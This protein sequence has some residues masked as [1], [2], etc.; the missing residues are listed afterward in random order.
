MAEQLNN[1]LLYN[2]SLAKYF[3][4]D[5]SDTLRIDMD[6]TIGGNLTVTGTTTS[7]HSESVLLKDSFLDLNHGYSADT[8]QQGGL[9]V[10]YDPTTTKTTSASF[11]AGAGSDAP[12][13]TVASSSGFAVDDIIQISDATDVAND[14][15]YLIKSIASNDMMVYG[16]GGTSV[17]AAHTWAKNQFTTNGSD[18]A[19]T[20][21]KVAISIMKVDSSGDWQVGK[22]SNIGSL[23]YAAIQTGTDSS[24][25]LQSAYEAGN[26]IT[27]DAST[28]AL[29]FAGNQAFTVSATGGTD[30]SGAAVTV[31][32]G[33]LNVTGGALNVDN[34]VDIDLT[35]AFA[36]DGNQAVSFG[37]ST[38]VASYAVDSAGEIDLTTAGALDLNSAAGS[39]DA[40]TLSI[41]STDTT[42]ITMTANSGSAKT[43]TIKSENSGGGDGK[44][45]IDADDRLDVA[46][47][48]GGLALLSGIAPGAGTANDGMAVLVCT[49]SESSGAGNKSGM[50][51]AASTASATETLVFQAKN[52]GSG[53]SGIAKFEAVGPDGSDNGKVWLTTSANDDSG[54]GESGSVVIDTK[55]VDINAAGAVQIDA[56]AASNF[57][58]S[59]GNL[60]VSSAATLDIDAVT[61]DIDSSGATDIL[62]A[63]T[64]SAKGATGASFGD[65]TGT[66]EFDGSGAV[67]E[68]GMTSLSATPSGAL[69]L[70]GGGVSKFGDDTA[71]WSFDGSG[72]ASEVGMT[73]L[74]A[75]PSG[76]IT[77]TAGGASTWSTSAGAL[78]LTSAAAATWGTGAGALSLDG[79]AGVNIVGNSGEIDLTTSGAIDMNFDGLTADGDTITL[80]A[81]NDVS[82]S[83]T[84]EIDLTCTGG[85]VDINA[86]SFD[87]DT[88]GTWD[89]RGTDGSGILVNE[90]SASDIF[91]SIASLN[92]GSG[93]SYI[94][95]STETMSMAP[96]S[97]GAGQAF[98]RVSGTTGINGATGIVGTA[99]EGVSAGDLVYTHSSGAIMKA[100]A[101]AIATS[102]VT[103]A[104]MSTV[105]ASATTNIASLDGSLCIMA[106]DSAPSSSDYGKRVYLSETAGKATLTP[107]TT[108][109]AVQYQLG[110][111]SLVSGSNYHVQL[112]RQFL[113]EIP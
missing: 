32:G 78:T 27:T 76:A 26:T 101:S 91:M 67:T 49:K 58:T 19:A 15:L 105:S 43:L 47:R 90:T 96:D 36:V 37:S 98:L 28:G 61:V 7:V 18:T 52:T 93:N 4:P 22:G 106:F 46:S 83:S 69:T 62:A 64:L 25:T 84:S 70:Q 56:A 39:W 1:I 12:K 104:A 53:G 65:D 42:N 113:A 45:V 60:T 23:S 14:G 111:L 107:P 85:T 13:V 77:L 17:P 31:S 110:I 75:T 20:V 71:Y 54:A 80:T 109:G 38:S 63:S 68:S 88:T 99:G 41:D 112:H 30:F 97:G 29:I 102:F 2:K 21:C 16:V 9:T 34:A 5:T 48:N 11:T 72:A 10:N 82:L 8:A 94:T 51:M 24:E 57:S 35:G 95:V 100:D 73:S 44:L 87:V 40:S 50:F 59:S 3:L 86:G 6:T 66:W 79:A 55:L 81:N 74:S 103:G 108:S 89:L 33:G 92:S